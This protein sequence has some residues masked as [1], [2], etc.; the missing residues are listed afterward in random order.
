M[1]SSI[2]RNTRS[3]KSNAKVIGE[4][5]KVGEVEVKKMRKEQTGPET[6]LCTPILGQGSK[7]L[8]W[9]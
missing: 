6:R 9:S 1:S 5:E 2:K 7:T 4:V 3:I 8:A